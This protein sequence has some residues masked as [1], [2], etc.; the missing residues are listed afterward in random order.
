MRRPHTK[1]SRGQQGGGNLFGRSTQPGATAHALNAIRQ[2]LPPPH[3]DDDMDMDMD[4]DMDMDMG[5]G[6]VDASSS[7]SEDEFED[8]GSELVLTAKALRALKDNDAVI[9]DYVDDDMR[10]CRTLELEALESVWRA[11]LEAWRPGAATTGEPASPKFPSAAAPACCPPCAW[12]RDGERT[13]I[14][15]STLGASKIDVP[16]WCCTRCHAAA[17]PP[18]CVVCAFA[19]TARRATQLATNY[20]GRDPTPV[21]VH[22]SAVDAF[23]EQRRAGIKTAEGSAA[24]AVRRAWRLRSEDPVMRAGFMSARSWVRSFAVATAFADSALELVTRPDGIGRWGINGAMAACAAC[25]RRTWA[26]L[27]FDGCFKLDSRYQG[28]KEGQSRGATLDPLV[29]DS[30]PVDR[31][32]LASNAAD[33]QLAREEQDA[34]L[35]DLD[36]TGADGWSGMIRR[37][38]H[39]FRRPAQASDSM[40]GDKV[41]GALYAA[42]VIKQQKKAAEGVKQPAPRA[43]TGIF[44]CQCEHMCFMRLQWLHTAGGEPTG[45]VTESVV[46]LE[47]QGIRV[48][49]IIYDIACRTRLAI[50][51]AADACERRGWRPIGEHLRK[52]G[53]MIGTFHAGKPLVPTEMGMGD[54]VRLSGHG[55]ACLEQ[56]GRH[57]VEGAA[58]TMGEGIEPSWLHLEASAATSR[59]HN[60]HNQHELIGMLARTLNVRS[61]AAL[62]QKL[63]RA[64]ARTYARRRILQAREQELQVALAGAVIE[65]EDIND[66]TVRLR[67]EAGARWVK[68]WLARSAAES[69][70][71]PRTEQQELAHSQRVQKE[72]TNAWSAWVKIEPAI[73][74][75]AEDKDALVSDARARYYRIELREAVKARDMARGVVAQLNREAAARTSMTPKQLANLG[76]FKQRVQ[77]ASVRIEALERVSGQKA[78]DAGKVINA[79]LRTELAEAQSLLAHNV[80][81]ELSLRREELASV[82]EWVSDMRDEISEV[83]VQGPPTGLVGVVKTLQYDL[84]ALAA[85]VEV[86]HERASRLNEDTS[87]ADL[88]TYQRYGQ[89]ARGR[90]ELSSL[91]SA[92]LRPSDR[93]RADTRQQQQAQQQQAQLWARRAPLRPAAANVP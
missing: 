48:K 90:P 31:P 60:L 59:H 89:D 73:A 26:R 66:L 53:R 50:A 82:R 56:H 10:S 71:R 29:V 5:G 2:A 8:E 70:L 46:F 36:V 21:W 77:R 67:E 39:A 88:H 9:A 72:E 51:A 93:E 14:L 62:P 32:R 22:A 35:R 92:L 58:M 44:G 81:D 6:E 23:A 13:I 24:V 91:F 78:T 61:N 54:A 19:G 80:P 4:N 28:W 63:V 43:R 68:A 11:R 37:W 45:L 52:V 83:L 69:F 33:Q 86:A 25:A 85:D 12:A 65:I 57:V 76:R 1:K 64:I 74:R 42:D 34:L 40:D 7:G 15:A 75:R 18:P 17:F 38:I 87:D 30:G 49:L 41:C 79:Q 47:T 3:D 84:E 16:L 27:I 20:G 55:D